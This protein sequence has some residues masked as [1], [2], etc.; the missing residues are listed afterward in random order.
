MEKFI[1]IS[2]ELSVSVLAFLLLLLDIFG[3]R[4]KRVF[5]AVGIIGLIL[6]LPLTNHMWGMHATLFGGA[7]VLDGMAVFF[8]VLFI[9]ITLL[10]FLF[11][12]D[13]LE[14]KFEFRGEYYSMLLF[15]CLGLMLAVSSADLLTLFISI[16]LISLPLYLLAAFEKKNKASSE[17]GLKYFLLGAFASAIFLYGISMVYG[18]VGSTK[19]VDI[20]TAAGKMNLYASPVMLLGIIGLL[21]GLGFK[22]SASPFHMWSPDVFEGAPTPVAAF[23]SVAPKAAGIAIIIR[24]FL[25]SMAAP[26]VQPVWVLILLLLSAMSMTIGNLTAIPQKDFKRMLAY[27]GIA[28]IGY[29]LLALAA[30]T[31]LGI[32]SAMF[33]M[34]LYAFTNLGA[35]G[36]LMLVTRMNGSS[37][38]SEF[39]GLSKRAPAL[40]LM[41]LLSLL[42]L[43]GIPPL[44]GFVGKFYL[45]L[46]AFQHGGLLFKIMVL[47]AILN[48]VVSLYYYL[49]V[50]KVAYFDPPADEG[51]VRV[52]TSSGLALFLCGMTI[53]VLGILPPLSTWVVNI[54]QSMGLSL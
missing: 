47:Y 5:A 42:S 28:Q 12:L 21:T 7:Y 41:L 18:T 37:S 15:V 11:S 22:I 35:F 48:S 36:V 51:T 44:A 40:A 3:V 32:A 39:A 20:I 4:S 24:L 27:S 52:P 34:I 9:F 8:K 33:Y 16:E 17:A 53:V 25:L 2:F 14:K 1:P 49:G 31:T 29:V 10:I 19:F 43:A 23:I 38:I 50:L 6:T 13:F 26:Q 45:F 46:A 54:T 30:A